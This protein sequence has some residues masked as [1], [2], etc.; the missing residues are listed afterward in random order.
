MTSKLQLR[1]ADTIF[2]GI[3]L[4]RRFQKVKRWYRGQYK[5][6]TWLE[7]GMSSV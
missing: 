3:E 2:P 5:F 4:D 1:Q 7:F 6:V